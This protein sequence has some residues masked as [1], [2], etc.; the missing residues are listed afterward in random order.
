MADYDISRGEAKTVL[1]KALNRVPLTPKINN[2]KVK[3]KSLFRKFDA[4]LSE[5]TKKL[6]EIFESGHQESYRIMDRLLDLKLDYNKRAVDVVQLFEDTYKRCDGLLNFVKDDNEAD[7]SLFKI[8]HYTIDLMN[9][10]YKAQ[11]MAMDDIIH[12]AGADESDGV[13]GLDF[14]PNIFW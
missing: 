10:F 12:N 1:L 14:P 2:K 13:S 3:S 9:E 6:Y 4:E 11:N 8:G 7:P 5:I